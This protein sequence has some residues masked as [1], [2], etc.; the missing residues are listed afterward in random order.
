MS[1]LEFCPNC[2]ASVADSTKTSC[3]QC[4]SDFHA[5]SFEADANDHHQRDIVILCDS[6]AEVKQNPSSST[7]H[8]ATLILPPDERRDGSGPIRLGDLLQVK[9]ETPDASG[10]A[11]GQV[12]TNKFKLTEELGRGGM[13]IILRGRDQTLHR[14]V[15]LK[16][17][18]DP[19]NSVQRER[20]IK[21]AQITGQLEHPNIV[22]VHE[23]G[24]DPEGRIFFAMKLVRGRTLGDILQ[25]HRQD[26]AVVLRDFPL[27]RLV[28]ILIQICHAVSFAHARGVLHRDLK[29]S[30][31]M[32]GDFGEVMLMDWGLA[33][34]GVVDV[35]DVTNIGDDTPTANIK[36]II[37]NGDHTG[38]GDETHD[39]TVLGTPVY[40]SPEQALGQINQLDQRSDVYSLG[41]ILYEIITLLSPVE[42][43]DVTAVLSNVI[44]GDIKQPED[45]APDRVIP[46]DLSAVAMKALARRPEQRYQNVVSMRA[47]L[48][49]FLDGRMVSARDDN[50]FEVLTRFVLR[51]R[52]ATVISSTVLLLFAGMV[53]FGYVANDAQRRIAE[54]ERQRSESLRLVA[55]R[56]RE[57]AQTSSSLA[58][59]EQQR[60]RAAQHQAEEQRRLADEARAHTA[61]A[62][63]GE[64]RLRQRSEQI[65]HVAALSLASEQISRR[66]YTSART[67]LYACP[68]QFR[69]WPWRRLA[70]LCNR[71]LAVWN[72]HVGAVP[73]FMIGNK[74]RSMVSIGVDETVAFIDLTGGH[75]E[76]QWAMSASEVAMAQDG[77][78]C[79]LVNN[80]GVIVIDSES[81]SVIDKI[82]VSQVTAVAVSADGSGVFI[83][84]RLGRIFKWNRISS[85][86]SQ[87]GELDSEIQI[88]RS[89]KGGGIVV[90][91]LNQNNNPVIAAFGL[92]DAAGAAAGKMRSNLSPALP[93]LWPLL[94]Q[95]T[96]PGKLLDLREDGLA[97][98]DELAMGVTLYDS[99]SGARLMSVNVPGR[100]ITAGCF[101]AD[102]K[103]FA[104]ASDDRTI[105][106][107]DSVT[108]KTYLSLEGHA[109]TVLHLSFDATGHRLLSSSRDGSVREWNADHAVDRQTLHGPGLAR[110]II[111]DDA[112][113]RLVIAHGDG[114]VHGQSLLS[115][116]RSAELPEDSKP[117][118]QSLGFAVHAGYRSLDSATVV[119]AGEL[120]QVRLLDI[121]SGAIIAAHGLGSERIQAVC[122]DRAN[123][124]LVALDHKGGLRGVDRLTGR[125]FS[126]AAIP[127]GNGAISLDPSGKFILCGGDD[128]VLCWYAVGDGSLMRK[129]QLQLKHIRAITFHV[130]GTYVAIAGNDQVQIW[131]LLTNQLTHT[132]RG[133][134]G[135]INTVC[136]NKT[137]D[138]II[139]SGED[140]AVRWWDATSGRCLLVMPVSPLAVQS[141]QITSDDRDVITLTEDGS[142]QRW[143]A[144]D[145]R[146]WD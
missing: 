53:I 129:I 143:F 24:V 18:R 35:P 16:V 57:K 131:N 15:A 113:E 61:A 134:A 41:A 74:G 60:A 11:N 65:A 79:A 71:H 109:D 25:A 26:D 94:W 47:D 69:D 141:A 32:L 86:L 1:V 67:S 5:F 118:N 77:S 38:R 22:P 100:E 122:A 34:V 17:I 106:V 103:R 59:V 39:G 91:S 97:L 31:I 114:S 84:D 37:G 49:L 6:I 55:E 58:E 93:L 96:L 110:V 43:G 4:G 128:G 83:G 45:R 124:V 2:S 127:A 126:V 120:G 42:G 44:L 107:G 28:T 144:L 137:G 20:F 136:Y 13:G 146:S 117:W 130:S 8:A 116:D 7:N 121:N 80:E 51:H 104:F 50:L 21:E 27:S 75:R 125:R 70:L 138:R 73:S 36:P 72:N 112:G 82:K 30:N 54:H 87:V 40:M 19:Q 140:G 78:L 98:L 81:N 102:A 123:T 12:T 23:F 111:S 133:H 89:I 95:R 119:L 88:V 14:D 90:G 10:F 68:I 33:K 64:S 108:G 63:E 115:A 52:M 29:P 142:F 62:L 132:L 105:Q 99:L 101:S 92:A 48:E 46:R 3:V 139:S 56:E 9:K 76:H 135:A 145:R 85:Q 66:D